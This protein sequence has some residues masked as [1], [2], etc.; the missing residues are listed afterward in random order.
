MHQVTIPQEKLSNIFKLKY[1]KYF[2]QG[3]F[4]LTDMDMETVKVVIPH[5]AIITTDIDSY[6]IEPFLHFENFIIE[7]ETEEEALYF[8]MKYC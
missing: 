3:L 2:N 6:T 4:N 5:G 8:K 1:D 7:F